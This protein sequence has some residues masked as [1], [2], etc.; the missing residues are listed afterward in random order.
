[1]GL[2]QVL[3]FRVGWGSGIKL[4][5]TSPL[6]FLGFG[7][8]NASL[9]EEDSVDF[10]WSSFSMLPARFPYV[11]FLPPMS[12][13][14]GGIFIPN[15]DS[16]EKIQYNL[17]LEPFSVNVWVAILVTDLFIGG[18]IFIIQ[19]LRAN[20]SLVHTYYLLPRH[21]LQK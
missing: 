14:Y 5:G 8:P 11:D 4:S 9:F 13:E 18:F 1:M 21:T 12:K 7:S 16:V 10:I 17:F 15:Q 19:W 20:K 2:I 3:I 6:G